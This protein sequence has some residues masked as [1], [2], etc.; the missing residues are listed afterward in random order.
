MKK[1]VSIILM[2][3]L[4]LTA[5]YAEEAAEEKTS[6]VFTADEIVEAGNAAMKEGDYGASNHAFIPPLKLSMEG[7]CMIC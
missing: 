1:L 4:L 2:I 7:L 3:A 6:L 5:A